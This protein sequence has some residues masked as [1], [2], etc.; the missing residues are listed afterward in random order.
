MFFMAL[1][2]FDHDSL[3]PWGTRFSGA[4][5]DPVFGQLLDVTPKDYVVCRTFLAWEM[6]D[7]IGLVADLRVAPVRRCS[8]DASCQLVFEDRVRS[9]IFGGSLSKAE[10]E[11][12]RQ[13]IADILARRPHIFG[14]SRDVPPPR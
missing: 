13:A 5:R 12:L 2:F 9:H 1:T 6:C 3:L 14:F 11:W 8:G 10:A 4:L 7:D